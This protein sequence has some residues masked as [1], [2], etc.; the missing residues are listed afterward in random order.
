[1]SFSNKQKSKS[2]FSPQRIAAKS[3]TS[4]YSFFA[5]K[6]R[7][8]YYRTKESFGQHKRDIVVCRVEEACDSLQDT[9]SHFED[10]LEHFKSM[11]QFEGGSLENRYKLLKW[12]FDISQSKALTVSERIRAIEEVSEAL[13][14]E[15]EMELGQYTNRSLRAHSRQQ[16]KSTRQHYARLIKAMHRAEAK[17]KPVLSAFRDQVLFL[18]HNLNAQ[19]IAALQNELVEIGGEIVQLVQAMEKSINEANAFV[20]TLVEHKALPGPKGV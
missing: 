16:L 5:K 1:M 2:L 19:A 8:F 6:C 4:M 9:R 12:Q 10:A 20:S 14:S 11:T 7:H 3:M 18:K 15:W 17:I 13:F